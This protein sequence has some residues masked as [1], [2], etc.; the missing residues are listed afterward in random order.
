MIFRSAIL[1][2]MDAGSPAVLETLFVPS[3]PAILALLGTVGMSLSLFWFVSRR[4]HRG[5]QERAQ[6]RVRELE[7]TLAL[8]ERKLQ[9]LTSF[10]EQLQES[11]AGTRAI[12][13]N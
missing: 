2:L 3:G 10:A 12:I 6:A 7:A 11:E 5:E 1:L 13:D 9:H 4:I 8:Q